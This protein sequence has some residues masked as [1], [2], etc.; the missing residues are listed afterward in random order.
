VADL[1]GIFNLRQQSTKLLKYYLFKLFGLHRANQTP[2][3]HLKP[4][5]R[6]ALAIY[7][8]LSTVFF[9]YICEI[10]IR[11]AVLS[12][13]PGY[14]TRVVT[15]FQALLQLPPD[16]LK[17]L[18]LFFELL[19]RTAVLISLSLFAYRLLKTAFGVVKFLVQ[20]LVQKLNVY[21]NS[22]TGIVAK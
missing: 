5:A 2:L 12:M 21:D 14:P 22:Q 15:F 10:M 3:H 1:F 17:I 19:W 13:L 16:V 20:T 8:V 6:V 7:S 18:R 11:Y 4:G 9:F